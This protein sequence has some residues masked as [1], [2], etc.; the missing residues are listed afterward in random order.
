M[1]KRFPGTDVK[2]DQPTDLK[3]WLEANEISS[4]KLRKDK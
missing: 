4:N 2:P 3:L 1:M